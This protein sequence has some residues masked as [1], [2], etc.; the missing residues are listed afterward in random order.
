MPETL[1]SDHPLPIESDVQLTWKPAPGQVALIEPVD[2]ADQCLTG[3]VVDSA[4][5]VVVDLGSSPLPPAAPCEVT[6]SFFAPDAL[7]RV[8]ATAERHDEMREVIDLTV[9][10]V[11]RVQRRGSPRVRVDL[12]AVLSNLDDPGAMVS[13][14]GTTIDIAPGG[15][16]VRTQRPFPAGCDPTVT[17]E[18]PDGTTVVAL[19]AVLQAEAKA[20]EWEYRLVFMELDDDGRDRLGDYVESISA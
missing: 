16:R 15:C 3:V 8:R 9:H 14:V 1:S 19:A 10:D 6:A 20:G 2:A 11:E 5:P 7:Y 18:L 4:G 12:K 13:I 17:V